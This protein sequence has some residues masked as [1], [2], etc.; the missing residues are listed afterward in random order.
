MKF[1]EY[2]D[3]DPTHTPGEGGNPD[4][5][6]TGGNTAIWHLSGRMERCNSLIT[7]I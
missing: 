7:A 1:D 2:K 5:Y 3:N 4:Y 6:P